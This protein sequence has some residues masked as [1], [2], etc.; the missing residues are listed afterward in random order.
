MLRR[1]AIEATGLLDGAYFM[2]AE[3]VDWCWRMR[4]AGWPL[5]CVPTARVMH[6]AGASARQFRA[7]SQV[8]LWRSRRLLYRRFYGPLRRRLAG[9]IVRLGMR[10]E[11]RRAQAAAARGEISAEELAGRL[12]ASQRVAALFANTQGAA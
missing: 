10:A 9:L 12:E 1:E 8:N 11:A 3:E 2:Y 6:H 4:R 5:F 7:R